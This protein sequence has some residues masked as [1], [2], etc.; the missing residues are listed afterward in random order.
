VFTLTPAAAAQILRSAGH[1]GSAAGL[2]VAAKRDASGSIVYGMGFDEERDN[3]E[4]L[5][6]ESITVLIAPPSRDLLDGAT[7]DFVEL[8]EGEFQFI[9]INPHDQEPKPRGG[10]GSGG[11]GSC[12]G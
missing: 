3:D 11:C 7:L 6:C 12:G 2:R 4:V 8:S 9:F 5:E 10:C 1:H